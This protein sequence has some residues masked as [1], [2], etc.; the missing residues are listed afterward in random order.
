MEKKSEEQ[1]RQEWR[2]S[3]LEAATDEMSEKGIDI[4]PKNLSAY[5]EKEHEL[6]FSEREAVTWLVSRPWWRDQ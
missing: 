5:F 3:C 4:T 6:P 1:M 2:D